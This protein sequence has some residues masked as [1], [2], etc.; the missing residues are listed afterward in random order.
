MANYFARISTRVPL[1]VVC[2][3]LAATI[4]VGTVSYVASTHQVFTQAEA[5][6]VALRDARHAEI[7]R[8]FGSIKED[9]TLLATNEFTAEALQ[10]FIEAFSDFD[11][12]RRSLEELA[13]QSA[14]STKDPNGERITVRELGHPALT[15]YFHTHARYHHAFENYSIL[16]GYYDLFLVTAQGDIVYTVSKEADFGTNLLRGKWS[17]KGIATAFRK[18]MASQDDENMEFT[19]FELYQPSN[20]EPAA[21]IARKIKHKGRIIGAVILQMPVERVNDIML[22][23]AGMGDSG[24]TYIVGRDGLMRTNTRFAPAGSVLRVKVHSDSH[25]DAL[26]GNTNVSEVT[27]YRGIN[28]LSAYRPISFLGTDWALLAEIDTSE[29]HKPAQELGRQIILIAAVFMVFVAAIAIA[30]SRTITGPLAGLSTAINEFRS[31][32]SVVDLP[33]RSKRDEIGEIARGFDAT[34]REVAQYIEEINQARTE[35]K[36]GAEDL[37]EREERIRSLLEVSPIGF[38]LARVDGEILLSNGALRK[39]IG[40]PEEVNIEGRATQFYANLADRERYVD[41]LKKDGEVSGYE[42]QWKTIDGTPIWVTISAKII[43][44]NGEPATLAWIDDITDRVRA[45]RQ[46]RESEKIFRTVIDQLPSALSVKGMDDRY[47]MVNR[48]WRE[49]Y[50]TGELDVTGKSPMEVHDVETAAAV[51]EIYERIR[52][53]GK[54]YIKEM[55]LN[56]ASGEE[57]YMHMTKFPIHD[58]DGI[59]MAMASVDVDLTDAREAEREAAEKS[60]LLET[61]MQSMSDGIAMFDGDLKLAVRNE[62]LMELFNLPSEDFPTGTSIYDL[63]KQLADNGFYGD[64]ADTEFIRNRMRFFQSDEA[65]S[66]DLLLPNGRYISIRRTPLDDGGSVVLYTDVTEQRRAQARLQSIVDNVPSLLLVFDH[67][68]KYVASNPAYRKILGIK[69]EDLKSGRVGFSDITRLLAERGVLGEGD[70]TQLIRER[71]RDVWSG[72]QLSME[73]NDRH[74][75]GHSSVSPDAGLIISYTDITE[76]KKAEQKLQDAFEVI[77]SSIRYASKIQRSVIPDPDFFSAMVEEFFVLWE[78]RDVVGGDFYWTGAWGD[79]CLVILG[80]CTGHG[81]PGAFMTLISIGAMERAMSEVEPGNVGDL[82]G[83]MN[84][85]I[86]LSLGQHLDQDGSGDGLELGAC[87]FVPGESKL[88]FAGARFEL[89][90]AAEGEIEVVKGTKSGV[91]YSGIPMAQIYEETDVSIPPGACCYMTTDGMIDQI[92]GE[93]RRMFGK[94]RFKQLLAENHMKLATKQH[95]AIVKA[96]KEYQ[97]DER[98]RDDVAVIGFRV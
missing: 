5:K 69:E 87:Y 18:T 17:T 43:S 88:K 82:I 28:V 53:S 76:T 57:Q 81:V 42:I 79:G 35:L 37:K 63:L 10:S 89:F 13:L 30:V 32:L 26:L 33:Q 84:Q 7:T 45:A 19:D 77:S 2:A 34:A 65:S 46:L 41:L 98:R 74:Y 24:E 60:T 73:L 16:R 52:Q 58:E 22:S 1:L 12:S 80:D 20:N 44:Y 54:P 23:T 8:Y 3:V 67:D 92:G 75:F 93:R 97:G 50:T 15:R 66:G 39:I 51:T 55:S 62:K 36:R 68:N 27:G 70:K 56:I 71:I 9:I 90:I 96:F 29:I 38:T 6:L 83:R 48:L 47:I 21:F 49:W 25:R 94:R 86:Q 95:N 14:Y 40:L 4:S 59:I 61:T 78:P 85:L 31:T 91:G 72:T 64:G 11:L